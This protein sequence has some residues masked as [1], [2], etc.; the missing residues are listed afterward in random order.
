MSQ[1]ISKATIPE[2][3]FVRE[4]NKYILLIILTQA[5]QKQLNEFQLSLYFLKESM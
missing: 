4:Q 3:T 1:I 5:I 2:G